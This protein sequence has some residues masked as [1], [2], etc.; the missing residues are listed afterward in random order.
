MRKI[1]FIEIVFLLALLLLLYGCDDHGLAPPGFGNPENS[2]G[3][4]TGNVCFNGE[5]PE[6]VQFCWVVVAYD[7]PPGDVLDFNYL[8]Q[9]YEVS[10]PLQSDTISFRFELS[11]DTTYN[12]VFVT[13]VG[14]VDSVGPWNILGQYTVPGDTIT[15]SVSLDYGDSLWIE[16]VADLDSVHIP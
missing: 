7:R 1:S 14:N 16:I 2:P 12:W 3:L 5:M 4:L 8:A 11:P 6:N 10:L 13:A 15:Q 9:Y